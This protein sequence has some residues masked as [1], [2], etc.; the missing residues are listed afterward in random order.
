MA[1]GIGVTIGSHSVRAVEVRKKGPIWQVVRATAADLE[2]ADEGA[3]MLAANAALASAGMKGPALVGLS[4]KDLIVR[5][6]R[7][8]RVP[9]WRLDMLMRFEIREVA[10]QSGG[11]VAADWALLS[12]PAAAGE[13]DTVLV[14]LARNAYLRP[15]LDAVRGSGAAPLGGCPRSIALY[16]AFLA[17]GK[18]PPGEVTMLL[19]LGG[20]NTDVALQRDGA[21]L[22]ARNLAGGGKPFTEALAQAFRVD[23]ETAE[24]MKVQKGNVTPRQRARYADSSEEKVANTLLTV[25]GGV[26][27]AVHSSLMFCKAQ[28]KLQDL[29][30]DRVLVSGA[31][32]RLKGMCDYLGS[33]LGIPVEPFD[34]LEGVDLSPLPED[35]A[36]G[37]REE[38]PAMAAAVGLALMAADRSAFRLEILP[39]ADRKKRD[40]LQHTAWLIASGVVAAG[41]LVFLYSRA[42]AQEALARENEKAMK[43]ALDSQ[44]GLG[45]AAERALGL[46]QEVVDSDPEFA[47]V[48]FPDF[49]A[50]YMQVPVPKDLL[51]APGPDAPPPDP[52]APAA[53]AIQARVP[54]VILTGSVQAK[55]KP[56]ATV[57]ANFTQALQA[58]VNQRIPGAR[59]E[60]DRAIRNNKNFDIQIRF[61]AGWRAVEG[62]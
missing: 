54:V 29:R 58:A 32:A 8:P 34:A 48:H 23:A 6:T 15:R 52:A 45:P 19:H 12:L 27:A 60:V 7:V 30:V 24:R 13:D 47:A 26:V 14:A 5:Y 51:P 44:V 42:G 35:Q 18:V 59:L 11:D 37:L 31:G 9:D 4:G 61:F 2:G 49:K 38:G 3:R 46:V 39:E 16:H 20:E 43:A 55:E 21:L 22:F 53:D 50:R 28:T 56:P 41:G 1:G 36:E 25:A 17:G 57:F 40:F 10:E 33:G 62:R